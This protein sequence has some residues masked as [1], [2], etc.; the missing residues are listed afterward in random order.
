MLLL[1]PLPETISWLGDEEEC[2]RFAAEIVGA[3]GFKPRALIVGLSALKWH[4]SALAVS[5][6]QTMEA[7]ILLN[8]DTWPLSDTLF[9]Y[10]LLIHEAC[11]VVAFFM[12]QGMCELER[13]AWL[14]EDGHGPLWQSLM[15]L[16]GVPPKYRRPASFYYREDVLQLLF[17][18]RI[19][20]GRCTSC[21]A[22]FPLTKTQTTHRV[23]C[24]RCGSQVEVVGG[25][26]PMKGK[27]QRFVYPR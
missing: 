17:P 2:Q 26:T 7:A 8:K 12:S 4:Q 24:A 27:L 21:K 10:R 16:C 3:F 11:H 5:N 15:V 6:A 25:R 18:K 1:R 13:E 14:G 9:R 22:I 20:R 23:G 19:H